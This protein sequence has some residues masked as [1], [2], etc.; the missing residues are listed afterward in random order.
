MCHLHGEGLYQRLVAEGEVVEPRGQRAHA[1]LGVAAA[2]L[3]ALHG[4]A[5]E[6]SE[7]VIHLAAGCIAQVEVEQAGGVV[8][9]SLALWG[10]GNAMPEAEVDHVLK[11]YPNPG[12]GPFT[13]E[14]DAADGTSL[15]VRDALGRLVERVALR[16]GRNTFGADL[17]PGGYVLRG[18]DRAVSFIVI[19]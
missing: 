6:V 16:N 19:R 10:G 4:A 11:L 15:E 9:A 12:Q 8:A 7:A 14:G 17:A 5:L 3:A 13:V 18:P 1:E 2:E